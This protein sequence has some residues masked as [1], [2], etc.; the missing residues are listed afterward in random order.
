MGKTDFEKFALSKGV[1]SH[2]LSDYKNIYIIY[3]FLF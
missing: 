1:G 3:I 2:L